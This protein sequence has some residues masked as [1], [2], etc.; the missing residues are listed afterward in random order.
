MAIS[1][2]AGLASVGSAMI[3][4]GKF[5]IGFGK[6]FQAFAIG[7]TLSA[8]SRALA[9]KPDQQNLQGTTDNIKSPISAKKLIY[10]KTRV[11]GT[12]VMMGSDGTDNKYLTL[13]VAIAGH[14]VNAFKEVYLNDEKIWDAD[15]TPNYQGIYYTNPS[16]PTADPLASLEFIVGSDT[17]IVSSLC[18][19]HIQGYTNAHTMNGNAAIVARL[20]YDPE[21][22]T[23]GIP[24]ITCVVEGN[25][26]YDPRQDEYSPYY[27]SSIGSG[28]RSNGAWNELGYT[29]NPAL[30]LLDYIRDEKYGLGE[31]ISNIDLQSFVDAADVCDEDVNLDGGGTQKRYTCDGVLDTSRSIRANIEDIL[32]TM[33]G[34]LTLV[35]GKYVLNAYEYRTPSLDINE[36]HLIEPLTVVT[37]NSRRNTYNA[38]KGMF[39]SSED[40]YIPTDYPAQIST[41]YAQD[42]GETIYLDMSL[43]LTTDN[44]RAQ[45]IAR[46]TM[47]KSR[48][49]TS[50]SMTLNLTGLKV[51]VGDNIRL[52]NTRLGYSNKI[53]EVI[54]FNLIPDADKGLAVQI[55]AIENDVAAYTWNT[56]DEID[57]TTGGTVSLY[58]GRTAEPVTALTLDAISDVNTDGSVSPAIGVSWTNPDD[59]F[60][61][62][63]EITWQNTTD[64]NQPQ[65]KQTTLG[66]PFIITPVAPGKSYTIYVYAI[67]ERGVRSTGVNASV[68]STTDF[69]P[70]V[71]SLY[72]IE[73]TDANAPTAQEFSTQSSRAPKDN[74]VVITTDT[75]TTPYSTH[76]W[77]YDSA[78]NSW[79]AND[80]F[81]TGDLIIDGTVN[82]AQIA[83][84]A[85]TDAKINTLSAD[86]LT[87]GTID[88]SVIT[89]SNLDA[90]NIST[91]TLSADQ[92]QVDGVTLDSNAAGDLIVKAGGISTTELA[93]LAVEASNIADD[94]IEAAKIADEAVENAKIAVDAIQGDVIAA[95]AI[96]DVK[97]ATNAVTEDKIN[98]LAVT[99]AKIADDAVTNLKIAA[100]AVENAQIAVD[101]IQGDVIAAGAITE[102]KLATNAVTQ[103]KIDALAVTTAKIA[104]DAISNAK[105][106]DNAV[107]NAQIAVDAIQ[108]DVIA[109]SAITTTKIDDAAITTA[110]INAG[111]V[112]ANEIA[113]NTITANEIA[114]T[115]ITASEIAGNTITASQ[116]AATTITAS[117]IASS[118]ITTDKLDALAVTA[119]KID[120]LAVTTDKLDAGA[121]TTD[122]LDANA[123]TAAKIDAGAVTAAKIDAGAVTAVKI[124]AG[125]V[126]AAK[127]D[128]GA[129]TTAK[130]DANAVTAAKINA[131]A[132]T[133]DKLD[134]LAVTAGK[135]DS[136]AVT[137]DKLDA[138]AITADK[139]GAN[140][141]TAAKIDAGAVTAAKLDAGAVTTD[142]L[143]ANAVTAAKIAAG[144]ITSNEIQALSITGAEIAGNTITGGKIAADTIAVSNL[145]GDVSEVFPVM[146]YLEDTFT[147]AQQFTDDFTLHAPDLVAK[148]PKIALRIDYRIHNQSSSSVTQAL[149]VDIQVKAKTAT[150]VQIGATNGVTLVS[151][152]TFQ[153]EIYVS[154]DHTDKMDYVGGVADSSTGS[155][156]VGQI[157]GIRYD[158]TNDRT[159]IAYQ[160]SS[161]VVTTNETLYYHPYAWA[162]AGTYKNVVAKESLGVFAS[163]YATTKISE[164]FPCMFASTDTATTFRIAY[165]A[166]TMYTQVTPYIARAT[167]TMELIA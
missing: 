104:D 134:A 132:V 158:V 20:R 108:G 78:T 125:A 10:G 137:T 85:V 36:S 130:L 45:R 145:T 123:V 112:T 146:F 100:D 122:K 117:E 119:A 63:Y 7:A 70:G 24:K 30:I 35:G 28:H 98:A 73:K 87:A 95:A 13:V 54:S 31:S 150:A 151:S 46:L 8:V 32:S 51:Q 153:H 53:F 166:G 94:A 156:G 111:A 139:I 89:V 79:V 101:A 115:T 80:D 34:T 83:D 27:D 128:A 110:K 105:I 5:A 86:K 71:P 126:T 25:R 155:N 14:R 68:T 136:L 4:A 58:D 42:D 11:G 40:N 2:I 81:I 107:E 142:K 157:I 38:V 76:V 77:M 92:I 149:S 141:V 6:A 120:A 65:Y 96:T 61:D 160:Q 62:R 148:K 167:G 144:T 163:R 102:V 56:S 127:I 33:I 84:L 69:V 37:K 1:A 138:G 116:I 29:S 88:A 72:R 113:A 154:G 114:A 135:I 99:N 23:Q 66:S 91:G 75:S 3:T 93:L 26:V 55:D 74:D 12:L 162:A 147:V 41:Q 15:A 164:Y 97:L 48:L 47:L 64:S 106:A 17:N 49:Q 52:S 57:F 140:A 133:T 118:A 103:D 18:T 124:D 67:N 60:T 129:V 90:G 159:Y 19:N 131:G 152:Q 39:S 165:A 59:A 22:Y 43:P 143:D 16:D 9:P 21:V 161:D 109:A 82:T 44:I 50:V 121:I